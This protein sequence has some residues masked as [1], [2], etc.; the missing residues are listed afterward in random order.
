MADKY[1]L[2]KCSYVFRGSFV[3]S[4]SKNV[5]E[6]LQDKIIGISPSGKILFIEDGEA[7][8]DRL[9]FQY[10]FTSKDII[11]LK[12]RQF[13]MPGLVDT[14]IHAP[15][16]AFTGTGYDGSVVEWLKKYTFP[17][18]AKFTDMNVAHTVYR[19]V[20]RRLLKN[21][22]TTA[23]YFAT[24]HYDA[25]LALC[26]VIVELGQR[27]YVGIAD[28]DF[29]HLEHTI[30]STD[31]CAEETERFIKH[32][33]DMNNPLLTPALTPRGIAHCTRS[34]MK[35]HGKLAK[36]YH[37]P[38]QGHLREIKNEL[39]SWNSD[40]EFSQTSNLAKMYEDCGILT[41]KTYFAHC[42]Y[43]SEEEIDVLLSHG[44][45]VSHCPCSILSKYMTLKSG[46]ADVR[47]LL[48]RKLK[49]GLGT[50]SYRSLTHKDAFKLAT[51]G[52]SEVLGLS[53]KIGNFEVG[54][55]FDALLI[56]PDAEDTPFDCFEDDTLEDV[57]QKF[58]YLGD[59]RN[60]LQVYVAGRPVAGTTL[61]S[62]H[63][64]CERKSGIDIEF[65]H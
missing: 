47:H 65:N 38:V 23:S 28:M 45:G 40:V 46:V 3:H 30:K 52:G 56:D 61:V 18:E 37:L 35:I 44:T 39:S 58:L 7:N 36:K 32:V 9:A 14:H 19:K 34:L 48:D 16:Y 50:D 51:L 43:V 25:T 26:D 15:Q 21:G 62:S 6:I 20:V 42:I 22:T 4:T 5:M 17:V 2:N 12:P 63:F 13:I 24:I 1:E 8:Q 29:S 55:E 59:D 57:I 10:G 27:A 54:K 53:D 64:S 33:L 60:I 11:F 31:C 41:D 49:V